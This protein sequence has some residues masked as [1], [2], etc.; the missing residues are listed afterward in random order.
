M[1]NSSTSSS[2][3][4]SICALAP[5]VPLWAIHN[6]E[7]LVLSNMRSALSEKDVDCLHNAYQIPR[8]TFQIHALSSNV[9]ADD[10]ISVEDMIILYEE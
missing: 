2:S 6:S 9:C 4:G 8:D 10:H 1:N 7:T 3:D 5:I